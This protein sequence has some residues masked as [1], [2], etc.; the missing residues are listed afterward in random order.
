M[1]DRLAEMF[2]L[3]RKLQADVYGTDPAELPMG[4]RLNFLT[5]MNLALQDELHEALAETGWKPWATSKHINEDAYK[6]ELVDAWHF[7]MN[8]CLAAGMSA[9]ELHDRYIAKRLKNIKRQEDGYDGVSTKC[10]GCKR[11]LDDDAVG[12][13]EVITS[14][15][16]DEL[17]I[18]IN[19]FNPS[20]R[21]FYC[22]KQNAAVSE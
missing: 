22:E 19:T 12:C 10:P 2:E 1:T 13:Y 21:I 14:E 18:G 9:D 11:A 16:A 4:D 17:G 8:L 7:F 3:Q 6:G 15:Q 20:K 5:V